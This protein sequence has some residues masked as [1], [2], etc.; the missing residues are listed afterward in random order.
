MQD[1]GDNEKTVFGQKLPSPASPEG[2]RDGGA[3][4]QGQRQQPPPPPQQPPTAGQPHPSQQGYGGEEK[5][6]FGAQLPPQ[7]PHQP[8]GQGQGQPPYGQQPP[9]GQQWGQ[10]PQVQQPGP[11]RVAPTGQAPNTPH[12]GGFG[13]QQPAQPPAGYEDTWLGG[14]LNPAPG[15]PPHGH[16]PA[17]QAPYPPQGQPPPYGQQP[18][19]QQPQYQPRNVPTGAEMFPEVPRDPQSVEPQIRPRISLEDALKGTGLGAGGSTNPLIAAAANL[20]ILLGRLRTGLV[21][22]QAGPLIDHVTRE[23]DLYERNAL[24]AG[25]SQQDASDAKYALA[26]TADDIVQNLPGADRSIWMQYS[27]IARFFGERDSGVGFFRKMDAAMSAP[28]QRFQVLE[29]MLTCLSLGFEGQYRTAHNGAVELARVRAAIYETLRAVRP[30]PDDDVSVHWTPVPLG[31]QRR[32]GGTPIWV[33][34][35]VAAVMVV[36]L[37]ATLS[38]LIAR[39]GTQVQSQILALHDGLPGITIERTVPVTPE[40]AYVAPTTGQLERIRE[41]LADQIEEGLVVVDQSNQYI[42]VRVGEA[43][44]FR[45]ARAELR[46]DFKPLATAIALALNDEPGPIRIVGHTDSQGLSG[47]GRYKTNEALSLARAQTV[48]DIVAPLLS[49]AERVT[50]EGLGPTEPIADNGTAEGRAMNRR[51]EIMIAREAAQ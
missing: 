28:G 48:A 34:A 22:M 30:R 13:H 21:E 51:V 4:A 20:L 5:T 10:Q 46:N 42:F 44:R 45:S 37:F 47:R 49:D 17:P 35:A 50:T 6:V 18:Y 32:Y 1:N 19:G 24:A 12:P 36:A 27:M 31:K 39:Q 25:V 26:A 14:A 8:Q 11:G 3:P 2:Q 9:Q 15:Q 33:V 16:A 43:L 40:M 41:K 23:I 29:V 38:T 7:Q